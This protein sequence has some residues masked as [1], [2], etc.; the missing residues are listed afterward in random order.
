M[1]GKSTSS[2]SSR[3][4]VDENESPTQKLRFSRS[5]HPYQRSNAQLYS[6]GLDNLPLSNGRSRRSPQQA[7]GVLRKYDGSKSE[8]F[9]DD[10]R[11]RRKISPSPSESGTEADDERATLTLR[12]LPAPPLRA[13]KG[14][15]AA[16]EPGGGS[17]ASPLLTPSI[18]DE[19]SNSRP[20]SGADSQASPRTQTERRTSSIPKEE[21]TKRRQ[22]EVLRRLLE[23]ISLFFVG[24]VSFQGALIDLPIG[25]LEINVANP[26]NAAKF[27]RD[28]VSTLYCD[29]SLLCIL[30]PTYLASAPATSV[31]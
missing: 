29:R 2:M 3:L 24:Y 30:D 17:R 8:Y 20:G 28:E 23:T 5:P 11:K 13:R 26:R 22:Y 31:W 27:R 7:N 25:K 10:G 1:T 4:S 21:R 9:D 14:L 15:K 19:Y 18:L 6:I 16:S 12:G